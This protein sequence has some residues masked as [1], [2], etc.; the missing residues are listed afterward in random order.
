MKIKNRLEVVTFTDENLGL[1]EKKTY[2]KRIEE[3]C[4]GYSMGGYK[5][6]LFILV[7]FQL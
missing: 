6:K 5:V 3:K 1:G 7:Q 4:D 2:L